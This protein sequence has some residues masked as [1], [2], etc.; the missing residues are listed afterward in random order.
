MNF[1]WSILYWIHNTLTCPVLDFLMPKI[2]MLGGGGLI[3]LVA[4]AG[5]IC[6]KKYRK[7]GIW[8]LCGLAIGVIVGNG[9]LKHLVAR[10]RPCWLDQS[11]P[12]LIS[13]P[14]DYSFPSGHTLASTISATIL[15]KTDRRFG[16][17]AIPLAAL[18]AFSR[19][20][21]FV[22]FPSDVLAAV[23]LGIFIGAVTWHVASTCKLR[24]PLKKGN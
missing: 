13:V 17:V 11:I 16:Y 10:S 21:L 4:A 23:V 2:T 22:H 14:S 18:I 1:D 3:W 19:L 5:M 7:Q 15:T 12:M 24:A 8:L 9:A 20:Y 6:S